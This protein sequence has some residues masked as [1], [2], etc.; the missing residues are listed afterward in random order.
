MFIIKNILT[1]KRLVDIINYRALLA[2]NPREINRANSMKNEYLDALSPA[3][4]ISRTG[5]CKK[6]LRDRGYIT[7]TLSSEEED[8]P[9]AY[10]VLIFKSI[11][12][13]EILLRSLYRPQKFYCVHADTKMSDVRR[14]AL[15]SIVNCFDNVFMSSQSYDVK[16]GKI[17]ILLVDITCT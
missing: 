14:K 7:S 1:K 8:F 17:I 3:F 9:I 11:N 2:G 13:F 16:W 15:E 5:D 4:Y 12:Q 10:S 6:V